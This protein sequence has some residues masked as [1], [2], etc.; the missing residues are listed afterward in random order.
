MRNSSL[1]VKRRLPL[2]FSYIYCSLSRLSE[3]LNTAM[4]TLPTA[5]YKSDSIGL[6]T[7]DRQ[8][9]DDLDNMGVGSGSQWEDEEE[10]KFYEDTIDLKDWVPRSFLNIQD[11]ET[12]SP[13]QEQVDAEISD[14]DRL[15]EGTDEPEDGT[16][17]G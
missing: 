2:P 11:G 8:R 4:P 3:L 9:G 5:S 12:E 10:R 16:E 17:Y 13:P 15:M 6:S 7:G 14:I 1:T